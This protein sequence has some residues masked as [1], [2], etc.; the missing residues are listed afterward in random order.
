[1]ILEA[2]LDEFCNKYQKALTAI[3]NMV[4]PE[5]LPGYVPEYGQMK[6]DYWC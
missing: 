2:A 1:M 3:T 6:S 4:P 5:L